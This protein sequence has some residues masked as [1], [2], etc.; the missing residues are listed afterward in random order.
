MILLERIGTDP[1]HAFNS[2]HNTYDGS[3]LGLP[4]QTQ[5]PVQQAIAVLVEATKR[6][7]YVDAGSPEAEWARFDGYGLPDIEDPAAC[8]YKARPLA[9]IWAT[10]PFLHDGSVPTIDDRLSERRPESFHHGSIEYDPVKLGFAQVEGSGRMLLDTSVRGNGNAGHWFTD[11]LDRPGRI[12]RGFDEGEKAEILEY[13]KV[14]TNENYPVEEIPGPVAVPCAD[15][16][17]WADAWV[18]KH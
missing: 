16:P 2:S 10:A 6:Q 3:A 9:G 14:A 17:N 11:E 8:G 7:A 13:L 15:E 12:G 18:G 5:T 1:L 4:T